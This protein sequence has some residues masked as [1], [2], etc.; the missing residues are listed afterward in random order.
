MSDSSSSLI[1]VRVGESMDQR[2][3]EQLIKDVIDGDLV[4]LSELSSITDWA[5]VK[6]VRLLML[7]P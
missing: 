3:I 5:S 2:R 6:K 7:L 4:P 1:V